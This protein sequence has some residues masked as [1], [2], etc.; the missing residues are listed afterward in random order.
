M[1]LPQR[2]GYTPPRKEPSS[3]GNN[4]KKPSKAQMLSHPL[5]EP[6]CI[7]RAKLSA[8]ISNLKDGVKINKSHS[9]DS[10]EKNVKAILEEK[11]KAM[12]ITKKSWKQDDP[13]NNLMLD[14]IQAT[15]AYRRS[16]EDQLVSLQTNFQTESDLERLFSSITFDPDKKRKYLDAISNLEEQPLR[17]RHRGGRLD[18]HATKVLVKW[19]EDNI[20]KPYPSREAK[21]KISKETGLSHSQI[22]NWFTNI[23]KRHWTPVVKGRAPR[24]RMD[25]EIAQRCEGQTVSV[26]RP[27]KLNVA[28]GITTTEYKPHRGAKRKLKGTVNKKLLK[29][30]VLAEKIV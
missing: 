7:E 18:A 26:P 19:F 21:E 10:S 4:L 14:A 2:E 3:R 16:L 23:R 30:E 8:C 15:I 17:R 11:R 12:N 9:D 20:T 6:L 13:L 24:S 29:E 5:A 1:T 22:R 28:A 25:V 27:E